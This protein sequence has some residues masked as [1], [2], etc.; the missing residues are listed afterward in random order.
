MIEEFDP[1]ENGVIYFPRFL[2]IM[3]RRLGLQEMNE[4]EKE[5]S[6]ENEEE[7]KEQKPKSKNQ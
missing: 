5:S 6:D 2:V 1:D 7:S 3:A 4:Q